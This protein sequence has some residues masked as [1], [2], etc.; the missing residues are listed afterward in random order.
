M[1]IRTIKPEFYANEEIAELHPLTRILFT[2]LWGLADVR[3]RLEDRPKRIKVSVL[4]YDD[5]DVDKA[6]SDLDRAGFIKRYSVNG[7]RLI[8]VVNFEKHQRISGKEAETESL[9]PGVSE[10]DTEE[11]PGKQLGSNGEA[12]GKQLGSQEGKGREGNRKGQE[13]NGSPRFAPPSQEEVDLEC[14]RI[15][16]PPAEGT[17]FVA[18][19]ASKGWKV[20]KAPM[21]DWRMALVGWRT[22]WEEY[23]NA[24][25]QRSL[26][27]GTARHRAE[28][29]D[30]TREAL[31]R[32]ESDPLPEV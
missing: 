17:K 31:N 24:N 1:R 14:A 19:Y 2:G 27:N 9:F 13:G 12:P 11:Q 28:L 22:R 16:L 10:A 15:G 7:G 23:R 25:T 32:D 30:N 29:A 3:G 8:Q 6:L 4:P 20:G 21:K 26:G 18:F 5:H